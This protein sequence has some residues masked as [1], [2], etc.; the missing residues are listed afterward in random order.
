MIK[1]L[2]IQLPHLSHSPQVTWL[3]FFSFKF[4]SQVQNITNGQFCIQ[5]IY[6][7]GILQICSYC[8]DTNFCHI[9]NL[10]MSILYFLTVTKKQNKTNKKDLKSMR[11]E[12]CK[13]AAAATRRSVS[14]RQ[15]PAVPFA[16][17]ML[18]C[19]APKEWTPRCT[20]TTSPPWPLCCLLYCSVLACL[21]RDYPCRTG[22]Q[23]GG[24]KRF[25][26]TLFI[27][28]VIFRAAPK[29]LKLHS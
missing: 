1:L 7:R 18:R 17:P 8:T 23:N 11:D 4:D 13:R 22:R 29:S 24:E 9:H 5:V 25:S 3:T 26:P 19:T 28:R 20:A 15:S 16:F 21:R 27:S 12:N 10:Q 2:S 6:T 14:L